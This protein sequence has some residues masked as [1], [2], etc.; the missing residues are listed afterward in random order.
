MS[1]YRTIGP[2][3]YLFHLM[4]VNLSY[5]IENREIQTR[6]SIV[7]VGNEALSMHLD[8]VPLTTFYAP[9]TLSKFYVEPRIIVHF[10]AAVIDVSMKPCIVIFLQILFEQAP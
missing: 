1:V 9:M 10:S 3:V 5:E 4:L 6:G 7:L 2:L 8:A